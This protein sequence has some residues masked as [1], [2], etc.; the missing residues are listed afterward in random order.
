MVQ[1]GI[2][3]IRIRR[4]VRFSCVSSRGAP[5]GTRGPRCI[6]PKTLAGALPSH[7]TRELVSD[8]VRIACIHDV[9]LD[10]TTSCDA[11]GTFISEEK[12]AKCRAA[13][14]PFH[15]LRSCC[16]VVRNSAML[17]QRFTL[18]TWVTFPQIK[19]ILGKPL[20]YAWS[21][22][23]FVTNY[24]RSKENTPAPKLFLGF[25]GWCLVTKW[26]SD[27]HRVFPQEQAVACISD[28]WHEVLAVLCCTVSEM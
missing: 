2:R 11:V 24:S 18:C 25:L 21:P 17:W 22:K 26:S 7:T 14:I 1:T 4:E 27:F 6:S 15:A 19:S 13:E 5:G 16:A 20:L 8:V 12:R 23:P 9:D 28:P 3:V 10:N